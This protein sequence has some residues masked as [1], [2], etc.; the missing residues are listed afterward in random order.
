M[1]RK[2]L[3]ENEALSV[4]VRARITPAE[5][6]ELAEVMAKRGL[7]QAEAIRAALALLSDEVGVFRSP[8]SPEVIQSSELVSTP[9]TSPK[10]IHRHRPGAEPVS[11]RYLAG[12]RLVTFV[13]VTCGEMLP[14]RRG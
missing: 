10:V 6:G 12:T 3:P 5:A 7:T 14:E 11:Q 4:T 1:P 13:C 2:P 9:V 8:E